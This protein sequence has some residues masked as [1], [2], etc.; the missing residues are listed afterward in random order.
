MREKLIT[1]RD[2]LRGA[3]STA[4]LAAAGMPVLTGAI[5]ARGEKPRDGPGSARKARVVLIRAK[6]V[7]DD[8]GALNTQVLQTMLDDAVVRLFSARTAGDAWKKIIKPGDAV[9]IKSN[10]WD[11]LPTPKELEEII[12]SR[13]MAAGVEKRNIRIDDRGAIETL[14]DCTALINVR[15]LRSHHWAGI[16]GC[17]KNYIMFAE[18]RPSHHGNSCASLGAIWN[19]PIV[20]GK[21]RLNILAV[22]TPQFYGRGPHHFDPRYVWDYRGLMISTDPVALDAL[23]ASLLVK[24][25]I[26]YFGENRPVTPTNHIQAAD[27]EYGLGVSDVKKIELVKLGWSDDVLI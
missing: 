16:G 4:A 22:L 27:I 14:K 6:E 24:K 13:V 18:D 9:G 12:K 25:R 11:F 15:P 17:I 8:K 26:A 23:G 5:D 7:L 1:R 3:A 10:V 21:T 20:K 2:F 19:L